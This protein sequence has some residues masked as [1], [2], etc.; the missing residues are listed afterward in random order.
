VCVC[1]CAQ[2]LSDKD[3]RDKYDRYGPAAFED[4]GMHHHDVNI[5]L[6][7]LLRQFG[8]GTTHEAVRLMMPNADRLLHV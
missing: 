3:K 4:G 8:F 2:V 5:S 1:A 6:E 7:E